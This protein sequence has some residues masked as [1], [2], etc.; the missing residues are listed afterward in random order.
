MVKIHGIFFWPRILGGG[1]ISIYFLRVNRHRQIIFFFT[2]QG[3]PQFL[4]YGD[5]FLPKNM[6]WV[7]LLYLFQPS[8]GN[9]LFWEVTNLSQCAPFWPIEI[10]DLVLCLQMCPVPLKSEFNWPSE[11][12]S[13]GSPLISFFLIY[14]LP[15]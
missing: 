2:T 5:R 8:V 11:M 3:L 7:Y 10:K 15:L 4:H 1:S 9:E 12:F 14:F 6:A 13:C